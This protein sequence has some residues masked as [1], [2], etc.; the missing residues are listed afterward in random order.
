MW[1]T[2]SDPAN[3]T[4]TTRTI[5]TT[6]GEV[7][8]RQWNPPSPPQQ[9]EELLQRSD[10][11]WILGENGNMYSNDGWDETGRLHENDGW[12]PSELWDEDP[13]E[14]ALPART[15]YARNAAEWMV[16]WNHHVNSPL[17]HPQRDDRA[18]RRAQTQTPA[19][20][21]EAR[22]ARA[23]VTREASRRTRP[24]APTL[25]TRGS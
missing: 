14:Q 6:T 4:C 13:A 8:L 12:G 17:T 23:S 25:D 10:N 2:P 15:L 9:T 11:Q 5:I 19:C 22:L 18:E 1:T 20:E 21:C 7:R 24:A 3:E 16:D